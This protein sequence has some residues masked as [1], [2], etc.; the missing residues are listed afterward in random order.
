MKSTYS[1]PWIP[2]EAIRILAGECGRILDV[3]GGA[4]PYYRASHIIDIQPFDAARLARNAWGAPQGGE[5][6]GMGE[7]TADCRP[8]TWERR[9]Q[10]TDHR[11]QT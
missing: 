11:M 4:A 7:K 3:G 10:T 1:N 6:A 9:L 5:T 2:A 8:Q